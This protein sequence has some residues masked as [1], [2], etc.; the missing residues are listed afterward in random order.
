MRGE[1]NSERSIKV[2]S[3]DN[4][5]FSKFYLII[6][7]DLLIVLIGLFPV[8]IWYADGELMGGEVIIH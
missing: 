7:R 3:T 1:N 4:L 8:N 6:W 5:T 2:R